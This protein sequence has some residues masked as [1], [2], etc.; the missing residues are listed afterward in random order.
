M[1]RIFKN[2]SKIF[3]IFF[4]PVTRYRLLFSRHRH[5]GMS[6]TVC[7]CL[8][9]TFKHFALKMNNLCKNLLLFACFYTINT[10]N[11]EIILM[12]RINF[13]QI[14]IGKNGQSVTDYK[15]DVRC[16]GRYLP[17]FR[18]FINH[19]ATFLNK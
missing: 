5:G 11:M 15:K 6:H 16:C 18:K 9:N 3:H 19:K 10:R 12:G 14:M 8:K 7:D 17:V 4:K 2:N 1:S 13:H